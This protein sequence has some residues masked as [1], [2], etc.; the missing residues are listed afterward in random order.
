MWWHEWHCRNLV[1]FCNTHSHTHTRTNNVKLSLHVAPHSLAGTPECH[2]C[3]CISVDLWWSV[4]RGCYIFICQVNINHDPVKIVQRLMSYRE[5]EQ[6][7]FTRQ[8]SIK[9]Y[10]VSLTA[11]A[12]E[13][14][15]EPWL[16]WCMFQCRSALMHI[17]HMRR[18]LC[19][20]A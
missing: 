3:K 13:T 20:N 15:T 10:Y 12:H 5:P 6:R 18:T 16:H 2:T 9:C 4:L 19:L 14:T 7:W 8:I 11:A 1:T 17:G